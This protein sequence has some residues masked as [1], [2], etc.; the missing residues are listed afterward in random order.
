[1]DYANVLSFKVAVSAAR[2]HGLPL[3]RWTVH[4]CRPAEA[5]ASARAGAHVRALLAFASL[6]GALMTVER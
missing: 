5:V 2:I 1:M 4:G 3:Q 6:D